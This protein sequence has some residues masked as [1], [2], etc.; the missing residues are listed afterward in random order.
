MYIGRKI[1]FNH[2]GLGSDFDGIPTTPEGLD[3]VSKFPGLVAELLRLGLTDEDAA[4]VVGRNILRVWGGVDRVAAEMQREGV[5]PAQDTVGGSGWS[6][7]AGM[8]YD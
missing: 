6:S 5:L 7:L 8:L 1:G 3:D 4:K 2:V